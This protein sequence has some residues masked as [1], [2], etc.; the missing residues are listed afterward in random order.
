MANK[1]EVKKDSRVKR[2]CG[3]SKTGGT[4]VK[5]SRNKATVKWDSSTGTRKGKPV[6]TTLNI[7]S[8]LLITKTPTQ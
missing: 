7:A 2:R 4:V 1:N 6:T 3:W 5:I 8:L